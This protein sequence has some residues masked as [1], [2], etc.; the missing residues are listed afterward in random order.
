MEIM[1]IQSLLTLPSGRR[2]RLE[3]MGVVEMVRHGMAPRLMLVIVEM[4][5]MWEYTFYT[6]N[7][8]RK[9]PTNKIRLHIN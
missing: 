9:T 6:N 1:Y 5:D 8:N 4:S 7:F 2:K 3:I